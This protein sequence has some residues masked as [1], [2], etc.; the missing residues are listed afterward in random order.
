LE[1]YIL[2]CSDDT[3]R[4]NELLH[5][6]G[7]MGLSLGNVISDMSRTPTFTVFPYFFILQIGADSGDLFLPNQKVV[8]R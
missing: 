5:Q 4:T 8:R 1:E 7:N 3:R 6:Y 2:F